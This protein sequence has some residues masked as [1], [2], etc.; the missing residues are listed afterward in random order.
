MGCSLPTPGSKI[1]TSRPHAGYDEISRFYDTFI[2]PR[3]IVFHRDVDVTV[4]TAGV[5]DLTLE[6]VMAAGVTLNVRMHLRYDLR[7]SDGDWDVERLRAHWELPTMLGKMLRRGAKF[8]PV[9]VR[10]ARQLLRNQGVGGTVGFVKAF[11][12]PG[13]RQRQCVRSFLDAAVAGDEITARRALAAGA[14]VTEGE[15]IPLALGALGDRLRGGCWTKLIAA[16]DTVSASVAA[17][18][19]RGVVFCQIRGATSGITRIRYFAES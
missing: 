14:V 6:I 13:R 9:S 8:L 3:E 4:G 18:S 15:D 10:L 1:V 7:Q 16:G 5:R 2:E 11:R 17:P 19:G 12:R